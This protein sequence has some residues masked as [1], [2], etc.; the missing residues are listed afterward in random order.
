MTKRFDN[1]KIQLF[2]HPCPHNKAKE[3]Y[4]EKN[5][6]R[7]IISV[8]KRRSN[9]YLIQLKS[10]NDKTIRRSFGPLKS[11]LTFWTSMTLNK[12]SHERNIR[13]IENTRF[14]MR[15]IEK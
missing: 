2:G 8:R 15:N 13:S 9:T 6:S 1:Y 3:T 10:K 14:S 12:T 11:V 4:R 5:V 7:T